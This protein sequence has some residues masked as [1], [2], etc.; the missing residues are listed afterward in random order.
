MGCTQYV[1][2]FPNGDREFCCLN[3]TIFRGPV[4]RI[5]STTSYVAL[6]QNVVQS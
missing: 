5:A 3:D 2:V 4:E 1:N 6:V